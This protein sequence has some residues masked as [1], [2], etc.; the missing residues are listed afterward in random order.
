MVENTT[1]KVGEM[2]KPDDAITLP[3]K[4]RPAGLDERLK[5]WTG[6]SHHHG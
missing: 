4:D 1:E 3:M 2:V 5:H 6:G